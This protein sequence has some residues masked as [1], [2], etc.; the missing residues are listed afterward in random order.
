M[1][2]IIVSI[3][4]RGGVV[5]LSDG[6][7]WRIAP[8]DFINLLW[9]IDNEVLIIKEETTAGSLWPYLLTEISSKTS[10]RAIKQT[11]P[12]SFLGGNSEQ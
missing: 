4:K 2:N 12:R 10:A 6:T 8:N 9:T 7:S 11:K 1:G 3:N 5:N